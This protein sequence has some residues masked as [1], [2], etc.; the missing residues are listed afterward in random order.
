MPDVVS[1][2][3][4]FYQMNTSRVALSTTIHG[5]DRNYIGLFNAGI[6]ALSAF[7]LAGTT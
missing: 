4:D 3:L 2:V 7:A 5:H 1:K 6:R